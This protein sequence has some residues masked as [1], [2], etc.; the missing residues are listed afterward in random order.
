[1]AT[2]RSR[3]KGSR[4]S[5]VI[6]RTPNA[7]AVAAAVIGNALEWYDLVVFSFMTV[8]ISA[9]FFPTSS[10]YSSI[11]MTTATPGAVFTARP[12]LLASCWV[13]MPIAPT[14]AALSSIALMT[15]GIFP[16]RSRCLTRPSDSARR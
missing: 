8:V 10:D 6:R 4:R 3:S 15:F 14:Q 9:L 2:V 5:G 11:L 1:M 13:S 16:L 7:R 12:I